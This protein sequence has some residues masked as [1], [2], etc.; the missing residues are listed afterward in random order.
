M[1]PEKLPK[2]SVKQLEQMAASFLKSAV[3][4]ITIPV[5][6]ELLVESRDD[7]EL[8]YFPGLS[9]NHGVLGAVFFDLDTKRFLVVIDD[10]LADNDV[11]RS[12]Y[13]MTVAE[14]LAHIVLHGDVIRQMTDVNDFKRLQNHRDWKDIE[15]NARRFAAAVLM[16]GSILQ[17]EANAI[18]AEL[19]KA[20]G[21]GNLDAIQKWLTTRLAS[22]FEVS[23][24]T[25]RIRLNEW[26][27]KI[28]AKVEA[29]MDA[30]LEYLVD[31]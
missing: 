4:S 7:A 19:V 20:V 30:R 6:I 16:P 3:G 5:D 23:F 24:Q 31:Y 11:Q 15:G 25:M 9:P 12:R 27:M 18:Y 8:D 29:S 1:I 13:R 17:V 22:R 26:P 21:F 2:F 14:E 10:R 28:M